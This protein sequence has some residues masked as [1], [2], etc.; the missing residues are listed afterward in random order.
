MYRTSSTKKAQERSTFSVSTPAPNAGLNSRDPLQ[1][2]ELQYA[3]NLTN[4]VSTPQGVSAREGYRTHATGISGYVNTLMTYNAVPPIANKMFAAAGSR[5]YDAT[6]PQAATEVVTGLLSSQ[7]SHINY[8]GTAGHYLVVCNGVDAPRHFN[9]TAW[10]TWSNV[11]AGAATTPGQ[12]EPSSTVTGSV[13]PTLAKFES[14]ISHQKRL[15]FVEKNSSRAWYLPINSIGGTASFFDFGALFPRGGTLAALTSWSMNGGTGMQNCLVAISSM[16]DL[17]IYNGTDPSDSTKWTL[18]GT[19]RLGAPVGN[20]CFLQYGGDTLLLSQ[21]GLMPLSKYMQQTTNQ[22]ALTDSIRPTLSALTTSQRG[23][24]G[25]QI[26]DYLARNLLILNIPQI[27]PDA[28]IQ[29]IFNTITGGWSLFTGWPAQC[30][31]TL[32]DKVYFGS[33]GAVSLAFIGYKDAATSAGTGGNTYYA[34]AQQAFSYFEKPGVKKRFVRAKVNLLTASGKPSVRIAC[35]VNW[36]MEPP[37]TIGSA[38][39][40]DSSSWGTAVFG[41]AKWSGAGL[42]NSDDWQ[43]LGPIGYSGSLSLAF[44]VNSETLWL[45]TDWEIELGGSH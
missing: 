45:A 36:S 1:S 41:A 24:S 11:A 31:A 7:W 30:W 20:R 19:W 25:F 23:L 27:N 44:P 6:L 28:N 38:T 32:G 22:S 12:V 33:N 43:T 2:M 5:I 8:T 3:V 21:D 9:G 15:W 13:V 16:G 35:R 37:Q 26:H 18:E 4:F 39:G 42:V 29:F 17:V 34:T 40:A 14:V 10:V